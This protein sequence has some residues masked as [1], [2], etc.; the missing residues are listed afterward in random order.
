VRVNILVTNDDGPDAYGVTLLQRSLRRL[1]PDAR[2]VTLTPAV[3][4]GGQALSLS[5]RDLAAIAV[6]RV[7]R[8]WYVCDVRPA[9]LVYL[10]LDY[11][12]RFLPDGGFD[13][14]FAGI[15]HGANVGMDVLHSGTVG[16]AM[17]ASLCYQLPAIAFSQELPEVMQ[18]DSWNKPDSFETAECYLEVILPLVSLAKDTCVN[19][20]FPAGLPLGW[21]SCLVSNRSRFRSTLEDLAQ[22]KADDITY[23]GRSYI[24]VS[25]LALGVNP[26][27]EQNG[28]LDFHVRKA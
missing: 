17:L 18:E 20:N 1:Y 28:F 22:R 27:P 7:D 16:M 19:V 11:S 12:K 8:D 21:Q 6:E 4:L 9:D 2:I 14:L 24:T 26:S 5:C 23:L 10:G 25:S 3:P 15:N 13:M